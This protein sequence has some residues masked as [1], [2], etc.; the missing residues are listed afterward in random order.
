[1]II[2]LTGKNGSGKG[3]VAEYLKEKGFVYFSLSDCLR[4]AA[5]EESIPV[6]RDNLFQLGN[7]LR[8][9]AGAGVLAKRVVLKVDSEKNCVIDSIRHPE[10]VKVLMELPNFRLVAVT[11][12]SEVRFDRMRQRNREK[13]PQTLEEFIALEENEASSQTASDQQL[14]ETIQMANYNIDNSSTL[15]LLFQKMDTILKA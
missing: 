4:D 1:M 8:K 12:L 9:E 11:A 13:D 3:A 15:E 10:E 7:R 5:M 14:D 6:V 2:G